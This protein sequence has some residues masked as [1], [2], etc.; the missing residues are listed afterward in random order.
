MLHSLVLHRTPAMRRR[1]W[2]WLGA[3]AAAAI[4]LAALAT[5]P[6][7]H[8][9]WLLLAAP[10]LEEIVFRAG[11][12]EALLQRCDSAPLANV[13]TAFTF[14]AAHVAVHADAQTALTLLP[15]LAIGLVYQRQ[16]RLAPCIA[17]HALF[18]AVWLLGA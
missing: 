15:A 7:A 12:Q 5:T 9:L 14:A 2:A 11:L 17:W 1:R 8:A 18:N 16:R 13:V 6:L 3:A 10:L 4:V